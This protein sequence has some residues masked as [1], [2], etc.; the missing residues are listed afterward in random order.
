M[1]F[2]VYLQIELKSI[3]NCGQIGTDQTTVDLSLQN[4]MAAVLI[5]QRYC[6]LYTRNSNPE[7][8]EG[9]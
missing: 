4:I 2:Y 8:S 7:A 9:R 1:Y 5:K 3:D 6:T